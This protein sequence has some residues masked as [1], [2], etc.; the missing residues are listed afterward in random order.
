MRGVNIP[1]LTTVLGVA[2]SLAA[3]VLGILVLTG[4]MLPEHVTTELRTMMGI[5]L[6]LFGIFRALRIYFDWK[7]SWSHQPNSTHP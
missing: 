5:V 7:R 1:T 4:L 3:F 2:A 6:L